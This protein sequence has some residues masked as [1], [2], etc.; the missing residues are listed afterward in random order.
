MIRHHTPYL[1]LLP[2]CHYW[3]AVYYGLQVTAFCKKCQ[4]TEIHTLEEW[5][6]WKARGQALDKP[7]RT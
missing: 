6:E 3:L 1:T 4:K 2:C 7:I 5:N